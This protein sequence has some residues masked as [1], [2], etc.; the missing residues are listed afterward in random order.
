MLEVLFNNLLYLVTLIVYYN[1][2]R[3]IDVYFF[4]LSV[5]AVT[6]V[7]C[8]IHFLK[9]PGTWNLSMFNFI[10]LFLVLLIF[11]TPFRNKEINGVNVIIKETRLI[12][13]LSYIYI[14]SSFI[15]IYYTLP[16]TIALFQGGNWN[17]L[18]QDLY[19]EGGL[20]LY[21]SR[22]ERIAKNISSYLSTFAGIMAFYHLTRPK[23]N[24]TMTILLFLSWLLPAFLASTLV[25]SRGMIAYLILKLGLLYVIFRIRIPKTRLKYLTLPLAFAVV[26]MVTYTM[27]VS[28]SRFGEETV[29]SSILTYLSHSMLSFNDG[30]MGHI[31]S[32]TNGTYFFSWLLDAFGLDSSYN[33]DNLGGTWGTAFIT[34]IGCLYFDFGPIGT[35]LFAIVNS[36]LVYN[37]SRKRSYDIADLSLLV[38][39][40]S[41]YVNG[42]FVSGPGGVISYIMAFIIYYILKSNSTKFI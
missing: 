5:Y 29:S 37:V 25:A 36:L 1:K 3:T 35:V 24:K 40:A 13:V 15:S 6:A 41:Y 11:I 14:I 20:V 16:N 2:K 23:V 26:G 9:A 4:I 30:L 38:F 42:V 34:F 21:A 27:I 8:S 31:H 39:F 7:L 18:R 33:L 32:Y 17:M 19:S 10:Y 28:I 22:L 12:K